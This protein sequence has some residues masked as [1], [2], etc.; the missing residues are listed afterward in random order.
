MDRE[1][2]AQLRGMSHRR[3]DFPP[4]KL[5]IIEWPFYGV[6][7]V[8]DLAQIRHLHLF[9]VA[10]QL[11][12]YSLTRSWTNLWCHAAKNKE[13]LLH[14]VLSHPE[15]EQKI[16][17]FVYYHSFMDYRVTDDEGVTILGERPNGVFL[18]ST[19]LDGEEKPVML[20]QT[21]TKSEHLEF[22]IR[23]LIYDIPVKLFLSPEKTE[24]PLEDDG[25]LPANL[26]A[27]GIDTHTFHP[28]LCFILQDNLFVDFPREEADGLKV[29]NDGFTTRTN[30]EGDKINCQYFNFQR[31][32]R[33][34]YLGN[35][36]NGNFSD[37]I[38]IY[39]REVFFPPYIMMQMQMTGVDTENIVEKGSVCDTEEDFFSPEKDEYFVDECDILGNS[40]NS[41]GRIKGRDKQIIGHLIGAIH[42]LSM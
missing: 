34:I 38:N 19:F 14:N 23:D 15:L 11:T 41:E 40:F 12:N 2:R 6:H 22:H 16:N 3:S 27:Y 30:G 36:R 4:F 13:S 39:G 8:E 33:S 24:Y 9:T 32:I 31:L 29:C 18:S 42:K 28:E 26:L 37:K 7:Y 25:D 35:K 10:M 1:L 17:M 21:V 5:E 20:S